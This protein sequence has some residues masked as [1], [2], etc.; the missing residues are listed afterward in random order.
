MCSKTQES[1]TLPCWASVTPFK[2]QP[3]YID[4]LYE[5]D[6]LQ[7]LSDAEDFEQAMEQE[8]AFGEGESDDDMSLFGDLGLGRAEE[9]RDFNDWG[10]DPDDSA[11]RAA[12]AWTI[13]CR[14]A[15]EVPRMPLGQAELWHFG[16][17]GPPMNIM[18]VCPVSQVL[19]IA[20]QRQLFGFS[21][22]GL[23]AQV[24]QVDLEWLDPRS[25]G[26][27]G[28]VLTSCAPELGAQANRI[29]CGQVGGQSVVVA[30]DAL[31]GVLVVPSCPGA[32]HPVLKLQN[33][34]G[35][36][37][38]GVSTWGIGL[39]PHG[40]PAA[41]D[42]PLLVSANDHCVKA[43]WI[44]P[45]QNTLTADSGLS[46]S[47]PSR[48]RRVEKSWQTRQVKD[49]SGSSDMAPSLL[50]CFADNL[51]SIDVGR[52]RAILGSLGGEVKVLNLAPPPWPPPKDA[53]A[54]TTLEEPPDLEENGR[55]RRAPSFPPENEP[56]SI[57]RS[58]APEPEGGMR[59]RGRYEERAQ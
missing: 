4:E 9:I 35:Q 19:W 31:G 51:P 18:D 58:F 22:A 26:S 1:Q 54:V 25:E 5:E 12:S 55:P 49:S 41:A 10:W 3:L 28:A 44:T 21:L 42:G 30:V 27:A 24:A 2:E 14:A 57:I 11:Q 36:S 59:R 45:P 48:S 50:H 20:N 6:A 56:P 17:N 47:F 13:S 34:F 33:P 7:M 16:P 46:P 23:E 53:P 32:K 38:T 37:S 8:A 43:W 52:G 29:R 39:S 40:E 15:W